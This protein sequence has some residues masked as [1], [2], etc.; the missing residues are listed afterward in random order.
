MSHNKS[1]I[2]NIFNDTL[3][4]AFS[5]NKCV[6]KNIVLNVQ[7]LT[8]FII[9]I[10][11]VFLCVYYNFIDSQI[12][13]SYLQRIILLYSI[14][15][16]YYCSIDVKI[17]HIFS[18]G[19]FYYNYAYLCD[20][21][22]YTNQLKIQYFIYSV[23]KTEISTIFLILRYYLN[24]KGILYNINNIIF[25][26]LFCK[27]RIID[28][29]NDVLKYDSLLYYF[30]NLHKN[31]YDNIVIIISCNGLYILNL[32][33]FLIMNKMLYKTII[34]I[35]KITT[36]FKESKEVVNSPKSY[37]TDEMCHYLCSYIL[38][39]NT[40]ISIYIF[41]FNNYV[42]SIFNVISVSFLSLASYVYHNHIYEKLNTKQIETHDYPSQD[43]YLNLIIDNIS[44][45][46]YSFLSLVAVYYNNHNF[47]KC[48]ILSSI[49]HA[50]SLC[51]IIHNIIRLP[52]IKYIKDNFFPI[53][54]VVLMIPSSIDIILVFLN[55]NLKNSIPFLFINILI[56][57]LLIVKPFYKLNHVGLHILLICQNYYLCLD[58]LEF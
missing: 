58:N 35:N 47:S 5:M 55:L 52:N 18:I 31:S 15:D 27:L 24:K 12:S 9:S 23:I 54:N 45:Y 8:V 36:E 46:S 25:Y 34:K 28:Y 20:I 50:S 39:I 2:D 16:L 43:D 6:K 42:K 32:Y 33:W 40:P 21:N 10:Y 22:A 53:L 13:F 1:I 49:L 14:I 7:N 48:I 30:V 57:L 41:S 26:V 56:C 19:Y 4:S 3:P 11:S 51:V 37:N 38:F 17:H 44:I 29:Y